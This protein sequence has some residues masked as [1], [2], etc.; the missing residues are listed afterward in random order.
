MLSIEKM[1]NIR[2]L[3]HI[4]QSD[5]GKEMG[6]SKNRISQ[7]ENH[8]VGLTREFHDR[9]MSAIYT[10]VQKDKNKLT[11]DMLEMAEAIEELKEVK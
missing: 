5:L 4:N 6:I 8:A 11:D 10:I 7:V 3:Y 1:R 2:N 9:Y